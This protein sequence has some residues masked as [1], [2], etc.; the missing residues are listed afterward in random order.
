M[1]LNPTRTNHNARSKVAALCLGGAMLVASSAASGYAIIIEP[2]HY[3]EGSDLST[4]APYVTLQSLDG[5]Y[6]NGPVYSTKP[7]RDFAA[8]TG[9]L[10]FGNHP[11]G[12]T[13]CVGHFDCI[14]GFGMT[15][16]QPVDWVSLKAVNDEYGY[17]AEEDGSDFGSGLSAEWY[18]FDVN[19]DEL[20]S[21]W[22]SGVEGDNRGTMFEMYWEIPGMASL[23]VGG[24]DSIGAFQF[25]DLRF[26]LTQ[27]TVPEPSTLGLFGMGLVGLVAFR[28]RQRHPA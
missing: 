4:I 20:A 26:K 13:Q 27:A 3:A 22:E 16:H 14:Q 6:G 7:R 8:P 24:H 2:D 18:A 17:T 28:R 12:W 19:G 10:S 15:F 1:E 23:V 11:A 21:G 9:E 5:T 25:D